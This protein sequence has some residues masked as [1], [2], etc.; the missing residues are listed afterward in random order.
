MAHPHVDCA[1]LQ[2]EN[3][4]DWLVK[5]ASQTYQ[6]EQTDGFGRGDGVAFYPYDRIG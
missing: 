4:S 1:P 6:A 5:G 2:T 3:E